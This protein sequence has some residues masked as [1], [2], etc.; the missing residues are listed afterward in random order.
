MR[1]RC[2]KTRSV[3][4]S[5]SGWLAEWSR[6]PA[7]AAGVLVDSYLG[8]LYLADTYVNQ[9]LCHYTQAG[10]L[11]ASGAI[12]AIGVTGESHDHPQISVSDSVRLVPRR[13]Q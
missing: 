8:T 4:G 9:M 10:G 13:I 1:R 11:A 5:G 3:P 2:V 6:G 7:A 12:G